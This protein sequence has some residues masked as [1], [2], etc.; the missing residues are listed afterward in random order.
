MKI[1][2]WMNR[3]GVKFGTSGARG[4]VAAM[5]D[6]VCFAYTVGF[7]QHLERQGEFKPGQPITIAGD[8]RPSSPRMMRACM[9]AV[10]YMGGKPVCAG[11][12]P[13]PALC[14][15]SY[16]RAMASIMVT[17][18]HIPDDRNGLKFNR[19]QGEFLKPD[20]I[21]MREEDVTLPDGLFDGQGMLA[22]D[23][24]IPL[25]DQACSQLQPE[26][27][28]Q[29]VQRYEDFFGSSALKG[30]HIGVYQHSAVGRDV[31]KVVLERLGAQVMPLGRSERFI[32]VDTE[33]V[34]PED[35]TLA[36]QW[37]TEHGLDAIVTTDGDSDRPLLADEQGNWIRGDV[38]GLVSAGWLGAG[39][40]VTPISSNTGLEEMARQQGLQTRR[41]RIGSPFVIEAMTEL[42]KA[43]QGPVVGY[44]A[45]GGFLTAEALPHPTR[46][47]SLAPLPTRDAVLPLLC[48]LMAAHENK[49]PLSAYFKKACQRVTVSDRIQNKPREESLGLIQALR[50]EPAGHLEKMGLTAQCGALVD[51]NELDGHRMTF[52]SGDVVHLRPSGNAPELRIYIES[53]SA[54]KAEQLLANVLKALS[55]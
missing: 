34:R 52:S 36:R 44:E 35:V 54:Q 17:G 6:E 7:L 48:G 18:S 16:S 13:T 30:L 23:H 46:D 12:V 33:A 1:S 37:A 55:Q 50:A 27:L 45:N 51:T 11:F 39:A 8:L 53:D 10:E 38:L 22:Q 43:G 28:R 21:A 9:A 29:Y 25:P 2:E 40:V 20:E 32:P 42:T 5:T 47:G 31:L 24:A 41:T 14:H 15:H 26:L 4:L 3:S 19:A 49:L